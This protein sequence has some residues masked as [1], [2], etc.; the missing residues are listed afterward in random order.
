MSVTVFMHSPKSITSQAQDPTAYNNIY[1]YNSVTD[2]K[3]AASDLF[4]TSE[5]NQQDYT[6]IRYRMV[7]DLKILKVDSTD[8]TTP[9]EG[10]L[11]RLWGTSYY[12]TEVDE[13]A[14][15][16]R[17]GR[18][19]FKNI[20]RGT[21]ALQEVDGVA[22]YQQ[23]HIQMTVTVDQNGNVHIGVPTEG[24]DGSITY[25]TD[26]YGNLILKYDKGTETYIIGNEPRIHGDLEFVKKATINGKDNLRTL[27]GVTFQI[28]GTSDYGN[29]ILML[30][31]SDESGTVSIQN[32]ELGSYEMTEIA[33][34]DGTI[35]S[36][37]VYT[38]RCDSSG[39]L[40]ISYTDSEG[41]E[42]AISQDKSGDYVVVNEPTHSFTL[43]KMD[44]VNNEALPGA[45]FTLT[46]TSDYETPVDMEVTSDAN[47]MVTFDGL[48][49]GSYVLKETVAPANH[50]LDDT[51]RVV[52]IE[53][54]GKVTIDGLTQL[55]TGWFP[56]ENER[57]SEG[58][59]TITKAWSDSEAEN[60]PIP[61]IHL[62]TEAPTHSLPV[63][64]I[65]KKLWTENVNTSTG[66]DQATSFTQNTT[67]TK[68]EV[69]ASGSGWI[70]ID[71]QTT[72]YSIYFKLDGEAAYWWSDASIVYF[73]A[74]SSWMFYNC[75][76]LKSLDLSGFDTSKVTNMYRMF[77]GCS[78]LTSLYVSGFDTSN[79][80]NMSYM[81][82][83]CSGLKSLD[84]S[85]FDTSNVTNMS[86]M[87]YGCSGLKSLDVSGFDTSNVTSMSTMFY[88]CSGLTSLDLSGFDTSNVTNMSGMFRYCTGLL[89]L[90]VSKFNTSQVTD[91]S[92]MFNYCSGLT[93]LDLS[94]FDTSNVTNMSYMFYWCSGLTTLDVS[95]FNTS[96]VT[97]MNDMFDN[98]S[99][100]TSLDVSGFN[101]SNVT[102]MSCMFYRCSS[103]TSLDVRYFDTSKVTSMSSMFCGCNGLTSLDVS[104]F[105]TSSVT[106]M[107]GMFNGCSSLTELDLSNFDTS[108]VTDMSYMF[109]G[110]SSLTSLD[111]TGFDT[112]NVTSMSY[113]FSGCS[114]LT[115]LNVSGFDTSKVTTMYY[116]F[117]NCSSLT[118]LNVSGFDT[119][120]VTTMYYMFSNCRGLTSLDVSG[121]N[122]SKVT[123][124]SNMFYYCYG[125]ESLDVSGFNTSK[126]TSMGS[127]FEGCSSLTSLD[128]T[129]FDTSKVTYMGSMF[130]GCR[131]LT[132]LD[133][134][135]FNTSNVTNMG[136]MFRNCSGL[137]S[138]DLSS[139]DTSKVSYMSYMFYSCKALKTIYAG[140]RWNTASVS[141]SNEMFTACTALKG[142]NGTTYDSTNTKTDKIYARIDTDGQPGYLTQG[143]APSSTPTPGS[144]TAPAFSTP[145]PAKA[146][147]ENVAINQT[148]ES[149]M[150]EGDPAESANAYNQWVKNGD[151]T[152][153][154]RFN[155]YDGDATYYIWEE[156][157]PG[158][159]SD[160]DAEH[161]V[162][163]TYTEGGTLTS[164]NDRLVDDPVTD[165]GGTVH[166]NYAVKI[167]NTKDDGTTAALTVKKTVTGGTAA[168]REKLFTFTVT[169]S[170]KSVT[171]YY[172]DMPFVKGVATVKLKH[173]Q[174]ATATGLPNGVGYTVVEKEA[175]QDGFTTTGTG[176]T[177][178]LDAAQPATAAFTNAK[179][180]EPP[181]PPE[182][183]TGGLQVTKTVE[184]LAGEEPTDEKFTFTITLDNTG[185]NGLYGD[186]IFKNGV[187]TAY[188]AHGETVTVSGLPVGVA[189]TVKEETYKGYTTSYTGET[190]TIQQGETQAVT[191]KNT[192]E[193]V[194]ANGFTLK[195]LV[196]GTPSAEPFTFFI[197]FAGLDPNSSYG[198]VG[199]NGEHLRFTSAASGA[200]R[201]SVKLNDN[202]T[203]VFDGLPVG[204]TYTVTESASGYV[205]SYTVTNGSE[206]GAIASPSG[207]NRS[208]GLTLQTAAETVDEGEQITVTFVNT[209]PLYDISFIKYGTDGMFLDGALLQVLDSTGK[210]YAEWRSTGDIDTVQLPEGS[211][212]LHEAEAPE[213]YTLAADI[214][215][216]VGEN[217]AVTVGG[218]TAAEVA[219]TDVE[220]KVIISKEDGYGRPVA[221]AKL[222][223]VDAAGNAVY[224]WVSGSE[225]REIT[226]VLTVLTPYTLHEVSAPNGYARAQDIPFILDSDG[227]VYIGDSVENGTVAE[228]LTIV[229]NDYKSISLP[230]SGSRSE[231]ACMLFGC[232]MITAGGLYA[233]RRR[234]REAKV[235]SNIGKRSGR[236]CK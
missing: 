90:D 30:L 77:S 85:G 133:V 54:N 52:T 38:V 198:Y 61:V 158:Y 123:N 47:G 7:G 128:V 110:C 215:F 172:G 82:F 124:M 207:A 187:A 36:Q 33:V 89:S 195:K 135:G 27:P 51:P 100:L 99:R 87:F 16:N 108:N 55:V 101:T 154:Y 73:P 114:S 210:V 219:M 150:Y 83:S 204:S 157:L 188:L 168:D 223:I 104:G 48:E 164:E 35:L 91:M 97:M 40:S 137:T 127:M 142:G 2:A 191:V 182:P 31:T 145:T 45:T 148:S 57:S 58:V 167:T 9:V 166:H 225:A 109:E 95:N 130:S 103:L 185:I 180:E 184:P 88:N 214:T 201:V 149:K 81:F 227:T 174:S 131:S 118:S 233:T 63:A 25:D 24:Q 50:V 115:S 62:D 116:M 179:T 228:N 186:L 79:V 102:N 17:Y 216:T 23:N 111:V 126:V 39:I 67:A 14:T 98:C 71:D 235:R 10:I 190:G 75:S 156:A 120:K 140:S 1:L 212:T 129:G 170:D 53:S 189:Y 37:T 183:E 205:A 144:H 194:P 136:A 218:N 66:L 84:V 28:S 206:S 209:S 15:T 203:A 125:L 171:G 159:T 21:Y 152:W 173:G 175:G 22:D 49:P 68:E 107:S 196:S 78:S 208:S 18:I 143:P 60:H 161:P 153:T 42:V 93:N 141:S 74:D 29:D 121:F 113:M 229:M 19:T 193:E 44:S 178:T 139:F 8:G 122:T 162:E 160:T 34:P 199:A 151:G 222:Q 112:S 43:W 70:R 3:S 20:E 4:W 59:I 221:G 94:N 134:S 119:S 220:T 76:K 146:A 177:G 105:K 231:L 211:Y 106:N 226:G 32:L 163:V 217:G 64:T 5:L 202:Q 236:I 65:D 213:G 56:V 224:S 69:T 6:Q 13:I 117:S 12:G 132:S 147:G 176:E 86:S 80:T 200:A 230:L 46:G 96:K 197:D 26:V 92:W 192:K 169:L 165:E 232:A 11:F 155:V 41:Q 138:L 234:R 72:D 181:P